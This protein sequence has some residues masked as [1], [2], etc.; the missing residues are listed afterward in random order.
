MHRP[1]T[2][3]QL[4]AVMLSVLVACL[5]SAAAEGRSPAGRSPTP[6]AIVPSNAD[7]EVLANTARQ[8]VKHSTTAASCTGWRSTFRPPPTIRVL[9]TLGPKAGTVEQLDF[10][11]Y[12][13]TVLGAEWQGFYPIEALKAG[14]IAVKQ[15]GWYY[16]IVYRGGADAT[17]A[18]YDVQDNTRD[19]YYQ[20]ELRTPAP[21]H[22]VA[23][24]ATWNVT[25]RK[26]SA[27]S[28]KSH[29]FLTGYRTGTN[30]A[31]GSDADQYHLYEHSV[32]DCAKQKY[33]WEQI[34]RT[35]W[36]P[37]LEIVVPGAHD[38]LGRE[39]GDAAALVH[40]DASAMVP[41]LYAVS[42]PGKMRAAAPSA[43]TIDPAGLRGTASVD[44]TNDGFDDLL[45]LTATGGTT[46][47]LSVAVSDGIAGYRAPVAWWQGDMGLPAASARLERADF[48]ADGH[49]DAG[50]LFQDPGAPAGPPVARLLVFRENAA[51]TGF[52]A[53]V[54]WWSGELDLA[55]ARVM[56][57]DWNG[58]GRADIVVQEDLG[59]AGLR[60]STATST[61]L[62]TG[63]G[64]L[65]VRLS[66]PDQLAAGTRTVVGD[67]NRD[68]RDDL[69]VAYPAM[70]GA[71]TV[72]D[73]LRTTNFGFARTTF[74]K[75]LATDP[76]PLSMVRI[77]SADVNFDGMSDLVLFR[78]RGSNGTTLTTLRA[79]YT[80]LVQVATLDDATLDWAAS[81]PY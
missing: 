6:A 56:A 68:G 32:Y 15:Y 1:P 75:S 19:Q 64:R 18:C 43:I 80:D 7:A 13:L 40:L 62:A 55:S 8:A 45:V 65:R 30:V 2:A 41:R 58:D 57:G 5:V 34:L 71:G 77:A 63:L 76:L 11:T 17:G 49:P 46:L 73:A 27:A 79:R 81:Q 28:H 61:T 59:T 72:I 23:L 74:W 51:L 20:P 53:P 38:I 69:W 4:F 21:A 22:S 48:N 9:R 37:R 3:A 47:R 66:A 70:T 44:L 24:D 35:Y 31:C 52:A 26:Y 60:F 54:T 50:V 39:P 25:V 16:T 42:A 10:R 12:V 29:F 14:A 78:N 36:N 67:I 33:T